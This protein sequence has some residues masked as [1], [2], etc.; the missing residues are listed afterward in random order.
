MSS[1]LVFCGISEMLFGPISYIFNLVALNHANL[2]LSLPSIFLPLFSL[3]VIV[4]VLLALKCREKCFFSSFGSANHFF[5]IKRANLIVVI[6][7]PKTVFSLSLSLSLCSYLS[8]Y[9]CF[10]SIQCACNHF[11]CTCLIFRSNI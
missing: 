6:Q 2:T 11:M 10:Y 9:I 1:Q 4:D 5:I 7:N 8:M 3:S